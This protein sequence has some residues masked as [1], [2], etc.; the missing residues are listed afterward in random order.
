M[1]ALQGPVS[2]LAHS[3]GSVLMWDIL[4]NQPHLHAALTQRDAAHISSPLPVSTS[5]AV[6]VSQVGSTI[7]DKWSRPCAS[8]QSCLVCADG[9]CCGAGMRPHTSD[10]SLAALAHTCSTGS[11]IPDAAISTG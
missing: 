1:A 7:P 11:C 3:L 5:A 9:N 10:V 4:S 6:S 2:I 8:C